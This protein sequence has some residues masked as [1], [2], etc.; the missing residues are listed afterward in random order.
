MSSGLALASESSP[1]SQTFPG[2]HHVCREAGCKD[3]DALAQDGIMQ[4]VMPTPELPTN[5][6][7]LDLSYDSGIGSQI[8]KFYDAE[9]VVLTRS[10]LGVALILF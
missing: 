2:A 8:R 7:A 10:L 9:G 1:V 3:S 4:R 5:G 6:Q